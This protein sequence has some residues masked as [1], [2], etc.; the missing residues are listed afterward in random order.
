M[1]RP[2]PRPRVIHLFDDAAAGGVMRVLDHIETSPQMAADAEHI[3]RA[4][5]RHSLSLGRSDA[6]II[7]SHLAISWRSLPMLTMLRL[8][9]PRTPLV[10]VEHSYTKAFVAQNVQNPRRFKCLLRLAYRLFDMVIAVSHAQDKWLCES[11]AV[12]RAKLRVIQ[13]CVDLSAFRAI[14]AP[15]GPVRV[16]GAIGRLDRQKGFDTLISAFRHCKAQ[17]LALHIYGEGAEEADLRRL[18]GDD[19]RIQFKGFASDP[20]AALA[21][22]DVVAM[23]SRWEAYGLVALEALA[24]QRMLLVSGLDGL[25][26]H[27]ATGAVSTNGTS[28]QTWCE[29]LNRL[30]AP[31]LSATD[32][33]P[34]QAERPEQIFARKWRDL[35]GVVFPENATF[36]PHQTAAA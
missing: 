18:A 34:D 32:I 35:I 24:A 11:G 3:L 15:A 20:S 29:A 36:R 31:S 33:R 23:P 19:R 27:V 26:D 21:A 30:P 10:H 16:I 22:V 9:H 13:S 17:D 5:D 2:M 1:T 7:V 6:D 28:V 4:V 12:P 25:A 8:L 14:A